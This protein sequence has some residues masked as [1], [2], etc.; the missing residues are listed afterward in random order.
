MSD[1]AILERIKIYENLGNF[2]SC[3]NFSFYEKDTFLESCLSENLLNE[4]KFP[5]ILKTV[6]KNYA[7]LIC[8]TH[9]HKLSRM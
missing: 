2:T 8:D 5:I 6:I 7:N 3:T 1:I 4:N 9:V